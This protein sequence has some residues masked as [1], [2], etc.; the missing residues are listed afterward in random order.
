MPEVRAQLSAELHRQLKAEAAHQGIPLKEL[1]A[2]VL[3]QYIAER[4]K[5]NKGGK[6]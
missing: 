3:E 4:V 5:Q 1:I 2:R 6:R